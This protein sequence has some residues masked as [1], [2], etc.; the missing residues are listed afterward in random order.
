MTTDNDFVSNESYKRIFVGTV[1]TFK[2]HKYMIFVWS[3]NWDCLAK[4]NNRSL[5]QFFT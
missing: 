4:I 2:M 3:R 5:Y 1:P